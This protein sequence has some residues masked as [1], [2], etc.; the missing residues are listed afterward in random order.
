MF[1]RERS[2]RSPTAS[3]ER[4]C[5][6][7]TES[8]ST[9]FPMLRGQWRDLA[10]FLRF[11]VDYC[12]VGLGYPQANSLIEVDKKFRKFTPAQR[13]ISETFWQPW[14]EA[15]LSILKAQLHPRGL[16]DLDRQSR[17]YMNMQGESRAPIFPT[18]HRADHQDN[19]FGLRTKEARITFSILKLQKNPLAKMMLPNRSVEVVT[20][21]SFLLRKKGQKVK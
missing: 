5:T 21:P 4:G 14:L 6:Y 8:L 10:T 17:F 18:W 3:N 16:Q 13:R 7:C 2:K 11:S 19:I 9:F 20:A 15:W 12:K 1:P